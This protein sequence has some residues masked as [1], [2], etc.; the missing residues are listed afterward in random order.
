MNT[1]ILDKMSDQDIF[2]LIYMATNGEMCSDQHKNILI[3]GEVYT[4]KSLYPKNLIDRI[5]LP[6]KNTKIK[7]TDSKIKYYNG[8]YGLPLI[9]IAYDK[10]VKDFIYP[11]MQNE[12][13]TELQNL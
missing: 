7:F 13:N 10:V 9:N 11:Q 2:N 12:N 5:L 3:R 4:I 8:E 1:E 6:S